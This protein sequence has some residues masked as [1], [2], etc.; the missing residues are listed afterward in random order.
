VGHVRCTPGHGAGVLA[1]PKGIRET[2]LR[3][4]RQGRVGGKPSG[5]G[6]AAEGPTGRLSRGLERA[7]G[8]GAYD[9]ERVW[10]ASVTD[11]LRLGSLPT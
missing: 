9:G 8:L 2:E 3:P 6:D 10:M 5:G 7:V 11:C 4:G 1:A